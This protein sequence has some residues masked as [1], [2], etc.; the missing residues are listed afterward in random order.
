[1]I[2]TC[3]ARGK[4]NFFPLLVILGI[5]LSYSAGVLAL[6]KS[7]LRPNVLSL[8]AG[9]GSIEGLGESFQPQLNTGTASYNVPLVVPI[10]RAGF[11]PSLALSYNSGVGNKT[12]GLGWSLSLPYIQR[13]TDKGLPYYTDWPTGDSKD[14]DG[15]G[16]VDEFDE[17]DTYIFSNG[18]ELVPVA[19]NVFRLEDEGA[20]YR[21][22]RLA[23]GW[24]V[25]RP[26]GTILRFGR[27]PD[28]RIEDTQGRVFQ[29]CLEQME[30]TN[31]NIINYVYQ[32]LDSSAQVYLSEIHYNPG[33]GAG[34]AVAI[35]YEGR[36]DIISDYRPGFELTIAYRATEI[37]MMA[38]GSPVRSY[39]LSYLP[40]SNTQPLSLLAQIAQVGGD[41]VTALP[42]SKFDYVPFSGTEAVSQAM[43]SAPPL[44]LQDGDIDLIDI[45]ADGL[46][47]ILDTR[48]A[49]SQPQNY[50]LNLGPDANGVPQWAGRAFMQSIVP[51]L[52]SSDDTQLADID[53]DGHSDL[54]DKFGTQSRYYRIN[55]NLSWEVAGLVGQPSF[56]LSDPNTRLVDVNNDKLIDIMRTSGGLHQVW[57]NLDGA[58]WSTGFSTPS[59]NPLVTFDRTDVKLSDMNG[60]R[61]LDLVELRNNI[62]IYYPSKGFGAFG[63]AVVMDNAPNG[64]ITDANLSLLDVNGDGRSDVVYVNGSNVSIWIN[65]GLQST[66]TG[67]GQFAPAFSVTGPY[68]SLLTTVFREADVNGNG[69]TDLLWNTLGAGANTFAFVDFAPLEQPYQL[70]SITNGI[71]A[72]TELTYGS[73]VR[74]MARDLEG[75]RVWSKGVPIAFQVVTQ[76][77]VNNGL[78]SIDYIS[79]YFYHD[80]YYDGREREFRG[81]AAVDTYAVG[82]NNQGAPSL[83]A[84]Y[85]FDTGVTAKALK[86]AI[87]AKE[88]RNDAGDIF[89]REDYGWEA[90]VLIPGQPG[91]V[92][93]VVFPAQTT[94]L[95]TIIEKGTGAP[96]QLQWN[97]DYDNYGNLTL[98]VAD[99]RIDSATWDDE[100]ITRTTYSGDFSDGQSAWILNQAVE[101]SIEDENGNVF[102][103]RQTFYDD[104]SFSI[105]NLGK[106]SK[107]NVTMV[108]D[109]YDPHTSAAF[110]KSV[111]NRYDAWGNIIST[112]GPLWGSK[113]GHFSEIEYDP[114]YHSFPITET[115]HTG[116]T[117][118]AAAAAYDI[119]F[120][121]MTSATDFNGHVTTYGYDTFGRL[122]SMVKPG[123]TA[124]LPTVSY[125]YELARDIG[126]GRLINWI[127]TNQ[128]ERSGELGTVDSRLFYDGLGREVMTRTEGEQAGQMV[129][130]GVVG[131]NARGDRYKEYLPYFESG[132]LDY[133]APA[134]TNGYSE[135]HYDALGRIVTVLQPLLAGQSSA[136]YSQTVYTP[137][138]K[139]VKDEEQTNPSSPR[140]GSAMRFVWDGLLDSNGAGRLRQVEEI[141][142]LADDGTPGSLA[143]WRTEYSYDVLGNLTALKDSQG[144]VST[145]MYDG[146]SRE[147]FSN[148]PNAGY[149]WTAY[150]DAGNI[151]RTRDAKGHE[152][153]YEHDG[154]NRVTAEY[155]IADLSNEPDDDEDGIPNMCDN[156]VARANADQRDTDQDGYGNSCDADFNNDN[157]TNAADLAYL[158]LKFFSSDPHADLNGDGFVNAADLAILKTGFFKAPGP[159]GATQGLFPDACFDQ[160]T[161]DQLQPG[162]HWVDYGPVPSRAPDVEYHYDIAQGPLVE[163]Q[164]VAENT[165]GKLAWVRDQSGESHNSYDSRGRINWQAK[166]LQVPGNAQLFRFVTSFQYDAMDRETAMVY[167]DG[168]SLAYNYN[169]RGLL[170]SVPNVISS[171]QYNPAGELA[172]L[173]LAA[174]IVTIYEHDARL[175][176]SRIH[177]VRSNDNLTLQ[178]LNYSFDAVSNVTEITD[179]RA[180]NDLDIIGAELGIPSSKAR[181]FRQSAT[182]GYD[183][184]YRLTGMAIPAT[185]EAVSYR[186][187]R[188]GNMLYKGSA[189][190]TQTHLGEMRY[191][192]SLPGTNTGAWNRNGRTPTDPPGPH[193]LTA[194]AGGGSGGAPLS[195]L[196]DANG[197][198]TELDQQQLSWDH[199]DRL[200]GVNIATQQAQ[201]IYDH[202]NSRKIKTVTD[203]SNQSQETV[204]Y[205]DAYSELRDGKLV[206]Y[207]YA[208]DSRVARSDLDSTVAP[209]YQPQHFYLA[210]YLGSTTLTL[211]P[212]GY[213][214]EAIS[215][216]PYGE[217]RLQQA[218]ISVATN[219]TPYQFTGKE[220]DQESGLSY[221]EQRYLSNKLARFISTDPLTVTPERFTDPQGW[222]S[223]AYGRNSPLVYSDSTGECF[224]LCIGAAVMATLWVADKVYAAYEA[225]Q[226]YKAI[227][228]GETTLGEVA[229]RRSTEYA[230]GLVA[231]AAGRGVVKGAKYLAKHGPEIYRSTKKVLSKVSGKID[232]FVK[233]KLPCSFSPDTTVLT[234]RGEIAI[235]ELQ[236]G[237]WVMGRTEDGSEGAYQLAAIMAK[238][239]SEGLLVTVANQEGVVSRIHTTEDH[240]FYVVGAG[241]IHAEE[242]TPNATLSTAGGD[243]VRVVKVETV[244]EPFLAYD[245][246]VLESDTFFVGDS[247]A[248]VHNCN[249]KKTGP[250]STRRPNTRK[251]TTTNSWDNAANGSK[252]NSKSCPDCG[253]DVF[254]NPHNGELRNTPDGWDVEHVTKWEKI[255]RQLQKRGA[256]PKEY[257]DAYND[258]N[259][260]I[261]R[262]RTCNRSDNKL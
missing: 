203:T 179:G 33:D 29:W 230:A 48:S 255:R 91:D 78:D 137:L 247:N 190:F 246:D 106:I 23:E 215:Y 7:A 239:H 57:Y 227:K 172:Q 248:L 249:G 8:P 229:A 95:R 141:V 218:A 99:G 181:Q 121:V 63:P 45:N 135:N 159:S 41:G 44:S 186:Y 130:S 173:Q 71:G 147:I 24:S 52:L 10:G 258:L 13:Q 18:E 101:Q 197:N 202:E 100:R 59:P 4:R 105:A 40:F 20:F 76:S 251:S 153:A 165:L 94:R 27:V 6:N 79:Q 140:F 184:L 22:E 151:M 12:F 17:F 206:K 253:K 133:S 192:A 74:E 198:V 70:K 47:D 189:S 87:L 65:L 111:R 39:R 212:E 119:G 102:A 117:S 219:T 43:P 60:D 182:Y 72:T 201:Y 92:R 170:E 176:L 112:Y 54:L 199:K 260:T 11:A 93:N 116:N 134:P 126:A 25:K 68:T 174:G 262:C 152:I 252:P 131:F 205:I 50:Y 221:F 46:P 82:D 2:K 234:P 77:L 232:D 15:D 145:M 150:D 21:F 89:W 242:L 185:G 175:R 167:P 115:I 81:F 163:N 118:L 28:S 259:N 228:R 9:P 3:V 138:A 231:G 75:G 132:T 168:T 55:E 244:Q 257:R 67:R 64:I 80:G 123:D 49:I 85:E 240:P 195:L 136:D 164:I 104:E 36:P 188:I 35:Q 26:D 207:V 97:F 30:D 155:Y 146:V 250:Y 158:K 19:D 16:Q 210:Q 157:I 103:K 122:T 84:S 226:D 154:A 62:C 42:P 254:G 166:H 238:L 245:L 114:I 56:N 233:R 107:G 125:D 222:N 66:D 98:E 88:V 58:L 38:A 169:S 241:W 1:M 256:T 183:D 237:D 73:L 109:W 235:N 214:Q 194:T 200:V 216:L 162:Q 224:G 156:C 196:Y 187:D 148:D 113:P 211:S 108:L 243:E 142:D 149:K 223:Y 83:S 31:G 180:N 61:L 208:A 217:P 110:I 193:A 51:K 178:D 225:H 209:D 120:G 177:S 204:L 261:L 129:V 86:G 213:V 96:V 171:V 32:R 14:N 128:R 160:T 5:S 90:R 220:R 191:G 139:T 37:R 143:T 236:V 53:G 69:S 34:M 124:A 161:G 144:N 127:E